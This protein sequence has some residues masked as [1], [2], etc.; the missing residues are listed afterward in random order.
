M[1]Q[2]LVDELADMAALNTISTNIQCHRSLNRKR[3]GKMS[4][5]DTKSREN[6]IKKSN[7]AK[8]KDI[9]DATAKY[10]DDFCTKHPWP[11]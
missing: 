4:D 7:S 11:K 6:W 3:T 5:E 1:D 2:N 9:G 8:G 10:L